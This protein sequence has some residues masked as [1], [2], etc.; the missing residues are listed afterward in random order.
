[1]S[2]IVRVVLNIPH[3]G[4]FDYT[5][6]K[7]I[8]KGARV[9]VP[10]GP[11]KAV[12]I[13]IANL[14]ESPVQ[15]LKAI[16]QVLGP[17]PVLDENILDLAIFASQYYHYPLGKVLFA[18]L[19]PALRS[20]K[21]LPSV[22]LP[23]QK[24]SPSTEYPL[25]LEQ[26]QAVF[27]ILEQTPKKAV[28]LHGVT[29][30]GKTEVYFS[31][32]ESL[33]QKGKQALIL[34]PEIMLTPQLLW[35]V[36]KRF[37]LALTVLLHSALGQKERS[38]AWL[39]A[40]S[41]KADIV[42]G[43][44]LAVFTPMPRLGIV[45][46]DE[47]QDSSYKQE[48]SFRYSA[49]DMAIVRAKKLAIPIILSSATPS[50]ESYYR[51]QKGHYHYVALHER[52]QGQPMP[53]VHL[54]D[55]KKEK[56]HE[57]L[58]PTLITAIRHNLEKGEQSLLYINR[59]GYAPVLYCPSCG[60]VKGCP[61]C[62]TKMVWHTTERTMLCHFCGHHEAIPKYCEQCGAITLTP[63]GSGTERI[64]SALCQLFPKARVAR[65]DRDS[66]KGTK[67]QA[68]FTSILHGEIDIVVGTRLVGKG[69][70]F[71]NLSLV[72]IVFADA[73]F[74]ST[75]FRAGEN[76][77]A[78]LLQV[79]GR[80]GRRKQAG[81]VWVQT[82]FP[83]HPLFEA[84]KRSDYVSFAETLLQERQQAHLPPFSFLA[85]L[86]AIAPSEEV[87]F[88]FL[89]AAKA[90]APSVAQVEIFDPAF[91]HPK[92]RQNRYYG[93]LLLR[94]SSWKSRNDFMQRWLP[95]L[96]ALEKKGVHCALDIDPLNL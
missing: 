29:A 85:L 88:D 16:E 62:S 32:I 74:F 78:E 23:Q 67:A 6:E 58:S 70:D 86:R 7:A 94:S 38:N 24:S 71:A 64:Y 75:D 61:N 55:L 83:D 35:R 87:L 18:I 59:R 77:F 30:S 41:G 9:I 20:K 54:I 1:M 5:S 47:E 37:P 57:G 14:Q 96:H 63:L 69:H 11:R 49:R 50:L 82:H 90:Q 92:K 53:T 60:W 65:I 31:V 93:Q 2:A 27:A 44:R 66:S 10:F 81:S 43:T 42:V 34:V 84:V 80:A 51:A 52:A 8:A 33:L 12:G 21:A 56:I 17:E 36:Q 13:V 68:I 3:E 89:H 46:V 91:S 39:L 79:A 4:A 22:T 40:A 73:A 26:Q 15:H 95:V 19:P 76:L 28:L 48:G 72:G 25:N 45:V